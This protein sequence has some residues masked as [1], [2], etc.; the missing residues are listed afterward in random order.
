MRRHW[1][2]RGIEPRLPVFYTGL[3]FR[4]VES[5]CLGVEVFGVRVLGLG[6]RGVGNFIN[7]ISDDYPENP[8]PFN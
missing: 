3:G 6:F 2:V 1:L 5:W 7:F 8:I 4:V